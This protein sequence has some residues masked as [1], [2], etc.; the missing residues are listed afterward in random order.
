M[1]LNIKKALNGFV[2]EEKI[3]G[4]INLAPTLDDVISIVSDYF[5]PKSAKIVEPTQ[6]NT[7]LDIVTGPNAGKI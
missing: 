4:L 1:E 6:P 3:S 5:I 7:S 2:V